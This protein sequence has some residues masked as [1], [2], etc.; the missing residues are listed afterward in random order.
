ME[1]CFLALAMIFI[2]VGLNMVFSPT[3]GS[4]IHQVYRRS[5][6]YL[7]HITKREAQVYGTVGVVFGSGM[8]WMVF[9]GKR[10]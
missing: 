9:T 2:T 1:W 10:K 8:V 4:V 7:E 5:G 6:Y 3:E